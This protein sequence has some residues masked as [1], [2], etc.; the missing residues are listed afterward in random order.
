MRLDHADPFEDRR[1]ALK[2][3]GATKYMLET[4]LPLC[5]LEV[6]FF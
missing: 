1:L 6:A 4:K 5:S 3:F 2:L